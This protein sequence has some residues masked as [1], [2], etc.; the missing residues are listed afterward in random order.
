MNLLLWI[1]QAL[2]AFYNLMGAGYMMTHYQALAK[3]W[4][5]SALPKPVWIAY[6]VLEILFALGLFL[7]K[8]V[9]GA[10]I[11]MAVLILLGIALFAQYTGFPGLF[12]ALI[13]A[14]LLAFVAYGRIALKPF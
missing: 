8:L 9:P 12:W 1:L 6:G 11:G 2:L 14:I 5:L 13:P 3:P 7:P 10:A 4:V